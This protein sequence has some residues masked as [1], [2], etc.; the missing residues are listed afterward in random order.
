MFWYLS[1]IIFY[2][3]GKLVGKLI[4]INTI[5]LF[6]FTIALLVLII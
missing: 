6:G 3:L 5:H 1:A 4:N 2:S